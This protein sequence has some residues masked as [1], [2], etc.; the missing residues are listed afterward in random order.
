MSCKIDKR[1]LESVTK[2]MF[3]DSTWTRESRGY[4]S[5]ICDRMEYL[6]T[7]GKAIINI[8]NLLKDDFKRNEQFVQYGEHSFIALWGIWKYIRESPKEEEEDIKL[9]FGIDPRRD[10]KRPVRLRE[11][12]EYGFHDLCWKAYKEFEGV[13]FNSSIPEISYKR[14]F[15]MNTRMVRVSIPNDR[16]DPKLHHLN[17]NSYYPLTHS[18]RRFLLDY[19]ERYNV[20]PDR[21]FIDDYSKEKSIK[22]QL[23]LQF[24]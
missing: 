5:K 14:N 6:S 12:D 1:K 15:I 22:R 23:G 11:L 21:V 8:N 10:I 18:Q 16:N 3:Y 17:I 19:I 7:D 20:S 9:R 24:F 2:Q 13:R 4:T